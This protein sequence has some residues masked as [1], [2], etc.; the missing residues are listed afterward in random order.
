[1]SD[2][3]PQFKTRIF[4]DNTSISSIGDR[5]VIAALNVAPH[6]DKNPVKDCQKEKSDRPDTE[7][8]FTFFIFKTSI[9]SFLSCFKQ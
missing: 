5:P 4:I 6:G 3:L 7:V 8:I 1:L 2:E 9:V